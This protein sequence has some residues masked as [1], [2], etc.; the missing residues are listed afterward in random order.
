MNGPRPD[1]IS[2]K[3]FALSCIMIGAADPQQ[4]PRFDE[5]EASGFLED[6]FQNKHGTTQLHAR[7]G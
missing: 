1:A 2:R 5:D 7:P 3:H 6:G 4:F